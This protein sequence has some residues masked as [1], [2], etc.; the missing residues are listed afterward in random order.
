L[1]G[2][3]T[4]S[5][6]PQSVAPEK[7]DQSMLGKEI[8]VEG[9]VNNLSR[10]EQHAFFKVGSLNAVMFDHPRFIFNNEKVTL[11]GRVDMYE[12]DLQIVGNRIKIEERN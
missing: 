4:A 12:G 1:L 3:I 8:A 7:V 6:E 2:I 9:S 5:A 11:E 10:H